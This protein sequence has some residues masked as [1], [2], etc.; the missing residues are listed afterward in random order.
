M[1]S[2]GEILKKERLRL[3][4][5][6]EQVE[7]ETR[8]RLK[9]IEA[10]ENNQWK[11]FSSH[12]YITG[13][14]KTYSNYLQLNSDKMLA[15]FRREYEKIDDVRFKRR[16]SSRYLTP[17]TK[18]VV[19]IVTIILVLIFVGYFTLQ[20]RNYL[21]PPNVIIIAPTQNVFYREDKIKVLGK[22]EKEALIMVHGERVYPNL[23]GEFE[24]QYPLKLGNNEVKIEVTGANG[25]KTIVTKSYI[26]K[27]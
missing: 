6:L 22:T 24:F 25:K 12:I 2:V 19:K 15:F 5:P 26:K 7:K 8:I 27:Q 4:I 18:Q 20:V 16:I 9:F 13:I 23:E 1:L 17:Q 14:I 21:L 3:Q 11:T 10:I